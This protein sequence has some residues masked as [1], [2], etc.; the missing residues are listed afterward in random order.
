MKA[1]EETKKQEENA[2]FKV[3]EARGKHQK[4]LRAMGIAKSVRPD[5]LQK[6]QKMMEDVVK[7]GNEDIKKVVEDARRVLER[8]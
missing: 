2:L 1:V 8:S 3:R 5:D 4:K 7:R 6:A